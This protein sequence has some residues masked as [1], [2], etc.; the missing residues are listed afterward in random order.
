M[1]KKKEIRDLH[2]CLLSSEINGVVHQASTYIF[3][4]LELVLE[5]K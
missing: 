2:A 1:E 4:F 5:K 3:L